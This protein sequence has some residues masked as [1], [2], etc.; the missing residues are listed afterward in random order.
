MPKTNKNKYLISVD[1]EG[2]TGVVDKTFADSNGLHYQLARR[3]MAN[4]VN[5]VVEGIISAD[6]KAEVVVR[7]AHNAALN[8][9]LEKL[10][11]R[12]QLLQ[13]W[14]HSANMVEGVDNNCIGVFL[15]GYHAGAE[16]NDAVLS[17]V[18]L[19]IFNTI[20]VNGEKVNEAGLAALYASFYNVPIAFVSGDNFAVKETQEQ[21]G[22]DVVGVVVKESYARDSVLSLSQE[23]ARVALFK[24]A[25]QATEKLCQNKIKPWRVET[26]INMEI[27]FFNNGYKISIYQKLLK[28]LSFDNKYKFNENNFTLSY[29]GKSQ[30]EVLQKLN[31]IIT[32][33]FGIKMGM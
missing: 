22:K 29:Q 17:H 18:F 12:A 4:D 28:I 5:A 9:D 31:L 11:P 10:H 6:P 24:G 15:V 16:N 32:L 33:I 25:K 20:K 30:I 19:S 14:G 21:L 23:Q 7:D 26:P 2:I 27:K 3:Y 1:M 13:G 8:L